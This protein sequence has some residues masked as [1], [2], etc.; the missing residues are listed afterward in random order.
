MI[1]TALEQRAER[2]EHLSACAFLRPAFHDARMPS[3]LAE[4]AFDHTSALFCAQVRAINGWKQEI[5]K[6]S[7]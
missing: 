4:P 6:L 2:Y 7:H 1:I 3:R 5:N